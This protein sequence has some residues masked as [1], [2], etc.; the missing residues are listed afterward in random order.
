MQ[1]DMILM[2]RQQNAHL[3]EAFYSSCSEQVQ[4]AGSILA[5][6]LL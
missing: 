4:Q 1:Q 6:S 5:T 2:Y 3:H